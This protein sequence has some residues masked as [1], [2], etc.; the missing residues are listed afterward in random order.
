LIYIFI[1][2]C[3][4]NYKHDEGHPF[5]IFF[6]K[7]IKSSF[8]HFCEDNFNIFKIYK[9]GGRMYWSTKRIRLQEECVIYPTG[10]KL[11]EPLQFV[12]APLCRGY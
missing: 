9:S 1:W 2:K 6:L 8:R 7:K 10:F 12:W 11:F 5:N 4:K 3:E